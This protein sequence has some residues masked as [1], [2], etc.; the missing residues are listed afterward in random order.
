MQPAGYTI[1]QNIVANQQMCLAMKQIGSP[2]IIPA[3]TWTWTTASDWI[4]LSFALQSSGFTL[5]NQKTR[6]RPY[7]PGMPR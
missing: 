6:P 2:Q 7:A 5:P 4:T 3:K 1:I